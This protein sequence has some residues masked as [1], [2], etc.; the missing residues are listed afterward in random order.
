M[1]ETLSGRVYFERNGGGGMSETKDEIENRLMAAVN[2]RAGWALTDACKE[3]EAAHL[4]LELARFSKTSLP[5][6][7]Q[8]PSISSRPPTTTR[9]R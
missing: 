4:M 3:L 1:K 7:K 2:Y 9:P 8:T 5:K 6:P